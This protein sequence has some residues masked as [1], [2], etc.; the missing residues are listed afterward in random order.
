M[1]QEKGENSSKRGNSEPYKKLALSIFR[2][3]R[4]FAFFLFGKLSC[5]EYW[6]KI[7]GLY[8]CLQGSCQE[9]ASEN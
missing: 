9:K 3:W 5:I 8:C 4:T 7:Y 1:F 6:R 2:W